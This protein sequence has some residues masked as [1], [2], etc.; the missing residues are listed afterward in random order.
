MPRTLSASTVVS[1]GS[2]SPPPTEPTDGEQAGQPLLD[3]APSSASLDTLIQHLVPTAD[4]YP[5]VGEPSAES[6]G[7]TRPGRDIEQDS[8][9]FR[10]RGGAGWDVYSP[11]LLHELAFSL[12]YVSPESLHLHLPAQLSSLHRAPGAPG[13]S[14]PPV[15][16][17]AAARPAS[18]GQGEGWKTGWGSPDYTGF[19]QTGPRG[20]Y[21]SASDNCHYTP[22]EESLGASGLSEAQNQDGYL[23]PLSPCAV[24][25]WL[26]HS[27][28]S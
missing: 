20:T 27:L 12:S 13:P 9:I 17:T 26:M 23:G 3:G 5:E 1:P 19:P 2:R 16:R 21:L 25:P 8:S 14:L 24:P 15:H 7:R 4:Y 10:P 28:K 18:A 6:I 22:D 11:H